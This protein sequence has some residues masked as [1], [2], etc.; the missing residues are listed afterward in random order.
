MQR[1]LFCR[2]SFALAAAL[3]ATFAAHAET[4]WWTGAIDTSTATA[5]NWAL[6]S[7]AVATSAPGAGDTVVFTNTTE[8]TLSN[9][10]QLKFTNYRFEGSALVKAASR[11]D[12]QDALLQPGGSIYISNGVTALFDFTETMNS[13]GEFCATVVNSRGKLSF[14]YGTF[15]LAKSG[16]VFKKSGA[17]V[18]SFSGSTLSN[19]GSIVIEEGTLDFGSTNNKGKTNSGLLS[20]TGSARKYVSL[21][22]TDAFTQSGPYSEDESAETTLAIIS[23]SATAARTFT[24]NSPSD[25]R[26]TADVY[27][28]TSGNIS[29]PELPMTIVWNPQ[30]SESV[31]TVARRNYTSVSGGFRVASGTLCFANGAK[32]TALGSI[33]VDN[34]A[35]LAISDDVGSTTLGCPISIADGGTLRLDGDESLIVSVPS[36]TTNGVAVAD[37]CYSQRAGNLNCLSGEGVLVVGAGL[38]DEPETIVATWDGGGADTLLTTAENWVG[39]VTPNL[40]DGSLVATFPTGAEATVP[41]GETVA[42]K[43]I[44]VSAPS[45]TL[46]GGEGSKVALGSSGVTVTGAAFT[47]ECFTAITRS[48]T[49]DVAAD[50]EFAVA[51]EVS[52]NWMTMDKLTLSGTGKYILL[53][54]NPR[55]CNVDY[56]TTVEARADVPL[57]GHLVTAESKATSDKNTSRV[58]E[59]YGNIF[60]NNFKTAI[61]NNGNSYY[62]MFRINGGHNV[63]AG[64]VSSA[65]VN[66]HFWRF[67]NNDTSGAIIENVSATFKGGYEQDLSFNNNGT[68][69]SPF[70]NGIVN[71]EETPLSVVR[72]YVG[73]PRYYR[74]II[75]L[76]VASN[77]TRRG[78][79][80]MRNSVLNTTVPYALYATD[81][82]QS[83]VL[84]N[85]M[86]TWNISADQGVNVFCGITNT[87][88]VAS[89]SGA[90]LHLRDDR[91]NT[92]KPDEASTFTDGGITCE[93]SL[94]TSKV[95]TNKVVFAENVNFSKEGIL[96]HWMEGV[97]TSTGSVTV[98]KG[99]LIFTTGSWQNASAVNVYEGGTLEL[100]NANAFDKDVPVSF[101]GE[102]TDGMLVIPAGTNVRL[103]NVRLNGKILNGSYSSGLVVGGGTLTAG[104]PGM[105]IIFR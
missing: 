55:L 58:V 59:C 18:F 93:V 79:H 62:H 15:K 46:K 19:S 61:S 68:H 77:V 67:A 76:N 38:P 8:L 12:K 41:A 63:F 78:I 83:G 5:G 31:M 11:G 27:N 102:N 94:T 36:L 72:M 37:G 28:G 97:S 1:S 75:N 42:F 29:N 9:S 25:I 90:T 99:R 39:D 98:K 91:L 64:E 69:F 101:E 51:A 73:W 53:A 95:Q 2:F 84:L 14:S 88:T 54:S 104:Y 57:G 20:V 26:F 44:S 52:A 103:R 40:T 6:E 80:I 65:N 24:F 105:S 16:C 89:S 87:A 23:K 17:G 100:R 48:Q 33:A 32:V 7:G 49:W 30:N 56:Y 43:G 4:Y 60:S 92:V 82:G 81:N 10:V 74:Q 13:A 35:T 47:N 86:A 3:A 34:G 85:D 70:Y 50:C 66:G 22:E 96:D 21:T 71:V 45:F